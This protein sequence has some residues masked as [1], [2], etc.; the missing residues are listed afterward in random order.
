MDLS[1]L[2]AAIVRVFAAEFVHFAVGPGRLQDMDWLF[3]IAK[4]LAIYDGTAGHLIALKQFS[5]F[6]SWFELPKE[7]SLVFAN[8]SRH[9]DVDR[10]RGA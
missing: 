7:P 10:I 5:S 3:G 1:L 9:G 4:C 6:S 8:F 2:N